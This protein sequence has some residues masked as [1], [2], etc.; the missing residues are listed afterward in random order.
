MEKTWTLLE[1]IKSSDELLTN[2]NIKNSRLNAEVLL[3]DTLNIKRIDLYLQFDKPL[4]QDEI[5]RFKEKLVRR[6]N[7]EPLQYIRGFTEF[8]GINIKVNRSVLIPRQETEVLV[9]KAIDLVKSYDTPPHIL[10]I[11]AG[12][13]CISIAIAKNTQCPVEAIDLDDNALAL[14]K[15]NSQLNDTGNKISF[16]KKDI[17]AFHDFNAYDVIVSNPPYIPLSEYHILDKEV[18]DFEP[19]HA[20]TDEKEGMSFYKII[21][22]IASRTEKDIRL[23]LEIGDGKRKKV[24]ELLSNYS[25]SNAVFYPD[26]M[27][28]ER[29]VYIEHH[30]Q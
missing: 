15:E 18:K 8:Y 6:L 20:L 10:D 1:I 16:Q 7:Y 29:V 30:K 9:E 24:E 21:F 3:A 17:S 23:L 22:D 5:K 4:S 26:L 25:F 11:G 12:S 28:I 2:R 19:K 13:G 14:A 27:G